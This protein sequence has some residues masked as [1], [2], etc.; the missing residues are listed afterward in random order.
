MTLSS[1]PWWCAPVFALG[2]MVTVPAHSFRA[3]ARARSIAAARDMPGVW[4]VFGS[5]SS[6]WTMRTPCSRQSVMAA[7]Y[8]KGDRRARLRRTGPNALRPVPGQVEPVALNDPHRDRAPHRTSYV[9]GSFLIDR[10]WLSVLN[11]ARQ[12]QGKASLAGGDA[13]RATVPPGPSSER[14][15]CR[16]ARAR[17][18]RRAPKNSMLRPPHDE[19]TNC[20]RIAQLLRPRFRHARARAQIARG[21]SGASRPS[22]R[23]RRA[24]ALPR[25]GV[26]LDV[27]LLRRRARLF[28]GRR[29]HPDP[30]RPRCT[31]LAGD[32]GGGP[33]GAGAPDRIALARAAPDYRQ[34]RQSIGRGG[35]QVEAGDRRAGRASFT[36]AAGSDRGAQASG[37]PRPPAR[38]FTRILVRHCDAECA[39]RV[40]ALSH[41]RTATR[42][43]APTR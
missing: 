24:E 31:T 22:R 14:S 17:G 3:P 23:D 32:L 16:T 38:G 30:P 25:S 20:C 9:C 29:L 35:R 37:P 34:P 2:W 40:V 11:A 33:L 4:A 18:V 19:L 12:H 43:G 41:V 36:A 26:L 1:S 7:G 42:A 5:S 10:F 15:A 21:G 39:A 27:R 8:R 28:R 6:E 13:R